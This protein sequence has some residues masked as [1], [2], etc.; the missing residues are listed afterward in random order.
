MATMINDE[1]MNCHACEPACPNDAISKLGMQYVID[2]KLCTECVGFSWRQECAAVCPT[3]SCIPDPERPESERILFARAQELHPKQA[4]DM[5]LS[6]ETSHF[7][8]K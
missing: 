2:P 5:Q 8:A 6:E 4:N 1:C 3:V 7:R